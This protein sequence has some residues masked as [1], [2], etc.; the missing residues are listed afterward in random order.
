[1]SFSQDIP[2]FITE[3]V[4]N[5]DIPPATTWNDFEHPK[6]RKFPQHDDEVRWMEYLGYG[7]DGLVLKARFGHGDP[8]AVKLV[9]SFFY[10]PFRAVRLIQLGYTVL[11]V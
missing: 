5:A 8:V 2:S 7:W 11:E 10:W 1:M 4:L 6:L 3:D 9:G